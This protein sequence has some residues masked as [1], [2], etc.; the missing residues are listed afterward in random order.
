MNQVSLGSTD[1]T[2]WFPNMFGELVSFSSFV[3]ASFFVVTS[4]LKSGSIIATAAPSFPFLLQTW[5][6]HH[7]VI[8]KYGKKK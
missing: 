4:S 7:Q 6:P 1:P 8:I 3:F 5:K 2:V